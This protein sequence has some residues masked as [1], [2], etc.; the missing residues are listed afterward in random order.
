MAVPIVAVD[1]VERCQ[2]ELVGDV[3]DEPGEVAL[4]EPVAQVRG[5]QEG[6][7]AVAA[8]EVVGYGLFYVLAALTPNT[9]VL[10]CQVGSL[11]RTQVRSNDGQPA[12]NPKEAACPRRA[13]RWC[14]G[15]WMR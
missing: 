6:L 3:E 1:L 4:G 9:L 5:E 11:P 10:T 7:V 14:V 15:W 12:A 8:Q 2:V 13:R